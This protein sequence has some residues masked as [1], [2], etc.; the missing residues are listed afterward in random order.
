[1]LFRS[2][3]G[4]VRVPV[5]VDAVVTRVTPRNESSRCSGVCHAV[6]LFSSSQQSSC[7]Q[8]YSFA[9]FKMAGTTVLNVQIVNSGTSVLGKR[10]KRDNEIG[11]SP[12]QLRRDGLV[13]HG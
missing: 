3:L 4:H 10:T 2:V 6:N 1:M 5:Q 12:A 11:V 7:G 9:V 13:E 8:N